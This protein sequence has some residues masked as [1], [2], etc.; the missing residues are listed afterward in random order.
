[1]NKNIW[2]LGDTHGH[3]G[4]ILDAVRMHRPQALIHVGDV[5]GDGEEPL[6]L[7]E[8]EE[9]LS[10][11]E[12]WWIPGNHDTDSER[13]YD[14]LFSGAFAGQNLDGRVVTIAGIRV[15]GLGGVFRSKVWRPPADPTYQSAAKYIRWT[16]RGSRW[17]DGLPLRH[18]S[19]IF[20]DVYRKLAT[21]RADVLVTHEAPGMHVYGNHAIDDLARA[22]RVEAAY[23]GH[24]HDRPDY[25]PAWARLGYR[26]YGVGYCGITRLGGE[27][28][29]PGDYDDDRA[30]RPVEVEPTA[31]Q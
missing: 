28:I 6:P 17:R 29:R 30:D 12:L 11:T 21:Q 26:A 27:V 31:G 1:M 13:Q 19:T 22:L 9:I 24:Q 2:I 14:A 3:F 5:T 15:A 20:P 23:H 7:A 4:H 16:G 18:R 25:S 8:M 10:L